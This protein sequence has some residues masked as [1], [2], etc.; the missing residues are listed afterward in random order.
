MPKCLICGQSLKVKTVNQLFSH[1]KENH[2]F[3]AENQLLTNYLASLTKPD[4]KYSLSCRYC[5]FKTSHT[6]DYHK[7]MLQKHYELG[8]GGLSTGEGE[9]LVAS[10]VK[11]DSTDVGSLVFQTFT[12]KSDNNLNESDYTSEHAVNPFDLQ[13]LDILFDDLMTKVTPLRNAL[14][15]KQTILLGG[16]FGVY[17]S[18][19]SEDG[20]DD[21][22]GIIQVYSLTSHE[23]NR[24]DAIMTNVVVQS[25]K[26]NS[27]SMIG[28]VGQGG[29]RWAYHR[30]G[31]LAINAIT[32]DSDVKLNEYVIGGKKRPQ[33]GARKDF[34]TKKAKLDYYKSAEFLD[35]EVQVSSDDDSELSFA[36]EETA[37]DRAMIDDRLV[38]EDYVP[39]NYAI[40]DAS[41]SND[42]SNEKAISDSDGA[43]DDEIL[44]LEEGTNNSLLG[45]KIAESA[46][47]DTQ[48]A[49]EDE[50]CINLNTGLNL[51]DF[52]VEKTHIERMKKRQKDAIDHNEKP[53][54]ECAYY[55]I[56]LGILHAQ[57]GQPTAQVWNQPWELVEAQIRPMEIVD[58]V[59]RFKDTSQDG[60][61]GH[62]DSRSTRIERFTRAFRS[63]ILYFSR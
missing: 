38:E 57:Q 15:H 19:P 55:S 44:I 3:D 7:H 29:S 2:G 22:V 8:G 51:T 54:G 10:V 9:K 63:V 52:V 28:R 43:S 39:I 27:Y 31:F 18:R 36:D 56:L 16:S 26:Q 24:D 5:L 21:E 41:S 1:Y 46:A 20:A 60:L 53:T 47:R 62:T 33:V 6:K 49:N 32:V 11:S 37:Q 23:L 4:I 59:K 50:G 40:Q 45:R 30:L 48:K 14:T 17:Y 58:I 13:C 61:T 42:K 12:Y 34:K 25:M 35:L